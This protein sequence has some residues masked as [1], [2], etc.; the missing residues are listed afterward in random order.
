MLEFIPQRPVLKLID[1]PIGKDVDFTSTKD[2]HCVAA[3]IKLWLRLLPESIFPV[4]ALGS[5]IALGKPEGVP[6]EEQIRTL[7]PAVDG[8]PELNK[9]VLNHMVSLCHEITKRQ[10]VS[11][12][13]LAHRSSPCLL[14]Q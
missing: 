1:T 3:L 2:P 8:L 6:E 11:F 7:R 14:W 13:L 5:F 9:T 10:E 4:S 12:D